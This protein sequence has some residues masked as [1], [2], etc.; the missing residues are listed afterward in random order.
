MPLSSAINKTLKMAE[1]FFGPVLDLSVGI[2]SCENATASQMERPEKVRQG[3]LSGKANSA[4][5][6]VAT[7]IF[8]LT[9]TRKYINILYVA[10]QAY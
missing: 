10:V 2:I 7:G 4:I 8:L 1:A 5:F 3:G 9:W 6:I